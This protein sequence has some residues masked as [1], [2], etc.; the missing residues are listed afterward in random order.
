MLDHIFVWLGPVPP[1]PLS[2]PGFYACTYVGTLPHWEPMR[3][4]PVN[5][6][7][8]QIDIAFTIPNLIDGVPSHSKGG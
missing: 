8:I 6:I 7:N 4:Y 2:L 3:Q 1:M 5:I